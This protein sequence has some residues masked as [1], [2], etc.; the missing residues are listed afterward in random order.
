MVI[1]LWRVS[2]DSIILGIKLEIVNTFKTGKQLI[3]QNLRIINEDSLHVMI[4]N[5]RLNMNT[6]SGNGS[7]Q[8]SYN[9]RKCYN[10]SK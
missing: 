8:N 5:P 1:T 2:S 7:T 10:I 4:I 9:F 6:I 3:I